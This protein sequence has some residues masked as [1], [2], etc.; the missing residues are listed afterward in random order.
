M[1]IKK[2]IPFPREKAPELYD[3]LKAQ[4]IQFKESAILC[5][6][7]IAQSSPHWPFVADCVARRNLQCQSETLFT[8]GE[9]KSAP[10]LR[11]RGK[12]RNGYPQPEK[13]YRYESITYSK[14]GYC[15]TCGCGLKQADAFRMKQQPKW[16]KRGF[17]L[18]N[19]VDDEFFVSPAVRSVLPEAS[20]GVEYA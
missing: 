18:L 20:F 4:G 2:H 17:M 6:L 3:Y 1:E 8:A 16:G 11:M 12:W 5:V 19:W 9:L 14:D 15:G 13:D 7:D 10:W